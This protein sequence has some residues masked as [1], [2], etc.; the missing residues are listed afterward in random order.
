MAPEGFVGGSLEKQRDVFAD[1][2]LA[3]DNT[4]SFL[5]KGKS[6]PVPLA[7]QEFRLLLG[8]K[9][10]RGDT[11]SKQDILDS[12]YGDPEGDYPLSNVEQV[13]VGRLR[14]KLE[15][16]SD[17]RFTISI[18]RGLGYQLI[19]RGYSQPSTRGATGDELKQAA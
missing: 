16:A 9:K 2:L 7:E 10:A 6:T 17:G 11:V 12:L 8:F 14:K 1:I 19:D 13:V 5:V 4:R 18:L 3:S 15:Q